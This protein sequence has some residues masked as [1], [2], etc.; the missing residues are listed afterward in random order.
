M[1]EQCVYRSLK[2]TALSLRPPSSEQAISLIRI[3]NDYSIHVNFVFGKS[4][5]PSR[6]LASCELS[7]SPV[8]SLY[9]RASADSI[10]S[11]GPNDEGT[12]TARERFSVAHELGHCVAYLTHGF[13]PLTRH[14]DRHR[15]WEQ[16]RAMDDFAGTLLVPPWLAG[17]WLGET[18]RPDATSVFRI[19]K[20]ARSCAVSNEVVAKALCRAVPELGFL[21]VADAV[22]LKDSARLFVVLHSSAGRSLQ[23]PNQ[24]SH[25]DN[26]DFVGL[27][28]G[29]TG[30]DTIH[31]CDVGNRR[32]GHVQIA[33]F[34]SRGSI[35]SR[36][37]EFGSTVRLSGISYW[38]CL[39]HMAEPRDPRQDGLLLSV[40]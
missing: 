25:L 5:D 28:A 32:L 4:F 37:R 17:R 3:A 18:A 29:R 40:L 12:L 20:W 34:A 15:Y 11:L 16:E 35:S 1:D 10:A 9:R 8:I 39:A 6:Y 22:R 2:Q 31:R 38:I 14:D 19:R 36:R 30:V 27:I 33:W 7:N 21:K 23:L 26:A 24:H 13:R